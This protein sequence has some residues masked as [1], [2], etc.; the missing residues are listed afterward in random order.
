MRVLSFRNLI[1]K[2]HFCKGSDNTAAD[3]L[4][5]ITSLENEEAS[6]LIN[7]LEIANGQ[8]FDTE[9]KAMINGIERNV[10]HKPPS[11]KSDTLHLRRELH[12][13]NQI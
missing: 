9:V 3:C 10:K 7:E 1:S 2:V 5:R 12:V 11:A 13:E 4:T 8:Y 6:F